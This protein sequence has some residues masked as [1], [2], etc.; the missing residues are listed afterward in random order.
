MIIVGILLSSLGTLLTGI[1]LI[2]KEY[3]EY[4]LTVTEY[5]RTDM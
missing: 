1:V 2:G 4:W 5:Q 3:P